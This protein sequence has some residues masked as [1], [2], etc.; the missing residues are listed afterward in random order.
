MPNWIKGFV[1][2]FDLRP[3]IDM[4]SRYLTGRA[5]KEFTNQQNLQRVKQEFE[6]LK[7]LRQG[8]IYKPI[9]GDIPQL[10]L[11]DNKQNVA[12]GTL[13]QGPT[14]KLSPH[15]SMLMPATNDSMLTPMGPGVL[16]SPLASPLTSPLT[17]P[18]E[19][20]L[21]KVFIPNTE[22]DK[23]RLYQIL[24]YK[25]DEILNKLQ[26]KKEY[27]N[28]IE[29]PYRTLGRNKL[30][31]Q[32]EEISKYNELNPAYKP[33]WKEREI[34]NGV[35][36]PKTNKIKIAYGYYDYKLKDWQK[37]TEG[38]PIIRKTTYEARS[39]EGTNGEN[40]SSKE[41]DKRANAMFQRIL[42]LKSMVAG[43]D[44]SGF[45]VDRLGKRVMDSEGNPITASSIKA[46][47]D[48]AGEQFA[49]FIKNT[50]SENFLEAYK[51]LF[52]VEVG[53]KKGKPIKQNPSPEFFWDW[54]K[55]KYVEG[56]FD[57]RDFDS[58]RLMFQ[59]TYHFDP[60]QRY[61]K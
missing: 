17:S 24:G 7:Q 41:Y 29:E 60:F 15:D 18:L 3:T 39:K 5:E 45:A 38:K 51:S 32:W 30:T 35:Y 40:Q 57:E 58:A 36:D 9:L 1:E 37:D 22:E 25:P 6:A 47:E 4:I 50:A 12:P 26:P 52:N 27:S 2:G 13:S 31:N 59:A 10:L 14:I 44:K 42:D 11:R 49:R 55:E 54:A 23:I 28:Y 43:A 16:T 19:S 8:G 48:A 46:N 56:T 61:G 20:E 21:R 34:D 53:G 33:E